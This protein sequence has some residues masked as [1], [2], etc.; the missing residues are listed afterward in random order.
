MN[1]W[2]PGVTSIPCSGCELRDE[3]NPDGTGEAWWEC[4]Q[5][6]GR[7]KT[8]NWN[9][10]G[11][12]QITSVDSGGRELLSQSGLPAVD[13]WTDEHMVVCTDIIGCETAC[14]VPG[15]DDEELSPAPPYC[16]AWTTDAWGLYWYGLTDYACDYNDPGNG[17]GSGGDDDD[18]DDGGDD[19][20]YGDGYDG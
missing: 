13:P 15:R 2:P 3:D 8:Q 1:P 20:G 11:I 7:S 9:Y 16:K 14:F 6:L 12:P 4:T 19:E 18:G 10:A 5:P 17:S